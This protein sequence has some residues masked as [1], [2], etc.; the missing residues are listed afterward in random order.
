MNLACQ[1][2]IR[3]IYDRLTPVEQKVADLILLDPG[4]IVSLTV[5][6]LAAQANVA[7]SG[8]IRFCQ[9]L[10]YAGFTQLKIDLL[11]SPESPRDFILPAVQPDD[12]TEAVFDKVFQSSVRALSDTLALLDRAKVREAVS[13][14]QQAS[15]I[16]FYGVGTSATIAMDAYFRLMRI[17]YPAFCATDPLIMR[18]AAGSLGSGQVAVGISHSGYTQETIDAIRIA[19]SHGAATLVI[20][21]HLDSPICEHA[22]IALCVFSDEN[23]YPIEAVS[24]R[25]AH[26]AVLDALCVALSLRNYDRTVEHVHRMNALFDSLRGRS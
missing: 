23:R 25:I 21:S 7:S 11:G 24:A 3:N 16:E 10:G 12:S 4:R 1:A 13:L 22:D 8:V 6:D 9:R 14:L 2:K 17:G 15:R 26:I 19:R 5:S 18:I 20:T